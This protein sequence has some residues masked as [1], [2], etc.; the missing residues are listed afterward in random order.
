MSELCDYVRNH[1]FELHRPLANE[2][3]AGQSVASLK[4]HIAGCLTCQDEIATFQLFLGLTREIADSPLSPAQ[5]AQR[6][7]IISQDVKTLIAGFKHAAPVT[8]TDYIHRSIK[9]V[10]GPFL[11]EHP[12]LARAATADELEVPEESYVRA[13]S[14]DDR[15][16]VNVISTVAT[17]EVQIHT[18]APEFL[19]R[20][21]Q[22]TVAADRGEPVTCKL[23]LSNGQGSWRLPAG[24]I[25]AGEW[26]VTIETPEA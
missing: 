20:A 26:T 21:V 6:Q 4:Q 7:E 11:V 14:V 3:V 22:V 12:A 5:A 8:L 9:Y 25:P 1:L 10:L 23:Q 17:Y 15:V 16:I 24:D 18:S 13:D 2:L 19:E